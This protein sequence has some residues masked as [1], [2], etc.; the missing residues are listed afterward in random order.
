MFFELS[1]FLNVF[2]YITLRSGGA[3]FT[4]FFI[5]L[6]LGPRFI[7]WLKS[8]QGAGQPIRSYAP[9]NH[10]KK[11]GTPTMGGLLIVFSILISSLVWGN[12]HS[13]YLWVLLGTLFCYAG[14]GVFDDY[15]KLTQRTA[16]GITKRQKMLLQIL[17]A[18]ATVAVVMYLEKPEMRTTL[19]F[20]FFK[21]LLLDLGW[22]Y[23]PFAVFV[24]VG[25]S[26]AVNFTD[27][28]DGLVSIPVI[29]V[30]FVLLIVGYFAGH[31]EFAKYLQIHYV[32]GVGET[33]VFCGALIG[34]VLGFLWYNAPPAKVFMGDTGSLALGGT[35][36]IL[37]VI[38]KQEFIL[39]IAGGIFVLE[40]VSVILQLASYK[41]HFKKPFLMAPIHHHFEKKGIPEVTVVVRFWI[42][43]ILLAILALATLKLR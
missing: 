1:S 40:A 29:T 28:L 24:V 16:E 19:T 34:A 39:A 15:I 26:N 21:N 2:K 32:P 14:I 41:Y 31:I 7:G 42:V 25:A 5:C 4:A 43:S 17:V 20:P 18:V 27:G 9:E 36:G 33:A 22:F 13:A 8:K 11:A 10:L 38:I 30:S 6:Y 3:L 23:L 12:W 37:S 35:L